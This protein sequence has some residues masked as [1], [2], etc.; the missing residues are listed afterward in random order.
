[1]T[2]LP[3]PAARSYGKVFNEIA[4]EYD[5]RRPAYPEELIDQ[6][7]QVAGIGSVIVCL[8][9]GAEAVS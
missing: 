7:C 8:R 9:S 2:R 5:R 6:A 4:A 1:M 3:E